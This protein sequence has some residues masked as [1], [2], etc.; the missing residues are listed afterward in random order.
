M[1]PIDD[2][3]V[4]VDAYEANSAELERRYRAHDL[5]METRRLDEQTVFPASD[6]MPMLR[7]LLDQ[8]D[9]DQARIAALEAALLPFAL[10]APAAA[11]SDDFTFMLPRLVPNSIDLVFTV[12]E[13]RQAIAALREADDHE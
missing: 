8:H 7:A 3:R 6:T 12:G 10:T 13:L 1:T 9:A 11:Y 4:L 5:S 2:I